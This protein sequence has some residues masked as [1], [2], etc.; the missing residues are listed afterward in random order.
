M[1]DYPID[2]RA[3]V[4]LPPKLTAKLKRT[5]PLLGGITTAVALAMCVAV[6]VMGYTLPTSES[7]T[8]GISVM[9]AMFSAVM[10][11]MTGLA[12]LFAPTWVEVGHHPGGTGHILRL[13]PASISIGPLC[14]GATSI[15][16]LPLF[17]LFSS[18]GLTWSEPQS[19]SDVQITFGIV[20]YLLMPVVAFALG[21]VDAAIGWPILRPSKETLYRYSRA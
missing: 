7:A 9:L 15:V 1:Y 21:V 10:L 3:Y 8:N 20:V 18:G 13:R 2:P 19:D 12:L 16:V 17:Y 14:G 5:L 6:P 4:W 11:L